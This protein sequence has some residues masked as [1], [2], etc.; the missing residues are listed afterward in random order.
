MIIACTASVGKIFMAKSTDRCSHYYTH[1]SLRGPQKGMDLLLLIHLGI[2]Y[3]TAGVEAAAVVV[4]IIVV[5]PGVAAAAVPAV[6]TVLKLNAPVL[7]DAIPK[8]NHKK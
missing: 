6:G 2:T 3:P 7:P 4:A 1:H 8:P 5:A